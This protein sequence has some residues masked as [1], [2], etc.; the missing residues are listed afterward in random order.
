MA[1]TMKAA[2]VSELG[3]PLVIQEV[4]ILQPNDNQILVRIAAAIVP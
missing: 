3:R 2:V 4:P 1:N